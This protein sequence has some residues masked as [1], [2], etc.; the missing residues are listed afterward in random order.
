MPITTVGVGAAVTPT[1]VKTYISHYANRKSR[2]EKP[3]AH[4]RYDEGLHLIRSFLEYASHHTVEDLQAFT[5]QW[6]PSPSWVRTENVI[7]PSVHMTKAAETIIAHLGPQGVEQVGGKNWWQWRPKDNDLK[8]EWIE[9][10][11]HYNEQKKKGD[12]SRRIMLYIHGGAYFFG[13]VDE[14]RYQMQRHARKLKAR[15]F[16]PRYR[17]APQFPFP[18]ALQDCLAAYLYLLSIHDPSEIILAGD[19]AGGGMVVSILCMLRDRSMPL[20][21]GAILISPWV[22]LTHSFPSLVGDNSF[23]YIP[24]HGFMQKPSQFWPPPTEDEME[25]IEKAARGNANSKASQKSRPIS[26][27][28]KQKPSRGSEDQS[29]EPFPALEMQAA[30]AKQIPRRHLTIELEGKQ[31]T[32]KEQIQMYTTNQLL[33]HPLVSPVLQPSL[34]GLPPLLILTGG[35]EVL[36]D[37]QIYLAHKAANPLKYPLGKTHRSLYDP[38]DTMLNKHKPTPV[39]LQVW[40]DLCH[41]APTLSFTRPAKYMYRSIAQFGAWALARAQRR[42]IEIVDDDNISIISSGAYSESEGIE[43]STDS[44][45]K[46]KLDL[47]TA[48]GSVGRAGDALPV[49]ENNMIRERIDRSGRLYR[50][51]EASDLPAL[52]LS[53]DEVGAVKPGPVQKWLQARKIWDDKYATTRRKIQKERIRL[54]ASNELRPGEIG[55]HPPPSSLAARRTEKAPATMK[56][57]KSYG[58]AMWSGWGSR[59]DAATLRR[60]EEAVE[61]E[62]AEE[63]EA[64]PVGL[65]VPELPAP[66]RKGNSEITPAHAAPPLTTTRHQSGSRHRSASGRRR[67]TFDSK[68][69]AGRRRTVT[70]TDAGQTEGMDFDPPPIPAIVAA[71]SELQQQQQQGAKSPDLA[72]SS[73]SAMPPPTITTQSPADSAVESPE[74]GLLSAGFIPKFKTASHLRDDSTSTGPASEAASIMTGRSR[75]VPDDASTCAVFAAPGVIGLNGQGLADGADDRSLAPTTRPGSPLANETRSVFSDFDSPLPDNVDGGPSSPTTASRHGNAGNDS[76]RSQRSLERLQSHQQD[77]GMGRMH[78]LR[79]TST[80]AVVRMEGISSLVEGSPSKESDGAAEQ[81]DA[82]SDG[83]GVPNGK[84]PDQ[85]QEHGPETPKADVPAKQPLGFGAEAQTEKQT[86]TAAA[87]IPAETQAIPDRPKLYGRTDTQFET[88]ME[89]P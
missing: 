16:A 79:S 61:M 36:R 21:A 86:E 34:G 8:A 53:P 13:S 67:K 69:Q 40:E 12:R 66:M 75:I 17:L 52:Q 10:R 48:T 73:T 72:S 64:Q 30:A 87:T 19:S 22:D 38:N 70:V 7:I 15:V 6:V 80:T 60:E 57:Q 42:A 76:P 4:I 65:G 3:T 82:S 59:H 77:E 62:N 41:V 58:L 47:N 20:P 54:F 5:A 28:A 32:L 29:K 56:Q 45:T 43:S 63:K 74:T 89:K 33:T 27:F 83:V 78:P 14:H 23:D 11:A 24:A 71:D 31:V 81:D 37:E 84:L 88:A 9:M 2:R 49:F 26:T 18:C 68:P 1:V 35:G 55:E 46:Q 50:L 51:A 39:Q 25:I 85:G 44:L